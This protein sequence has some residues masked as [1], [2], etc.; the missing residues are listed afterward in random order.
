MALHSTKF[1][2]FSI[3]LYD[4]DGVAEI[5]LNLQED[6][7]VDVNLLLFCYWIAHFKYAPS[8]STW[9]QIFEFSGS[10]KGNIIQ[11]LR[12]TR[13]SLKKLLRNDPKNSDYAE[14]IK[15]LK[16][17]ELSAEKIQQEAIQSLL[18]L[19]ETDTQAF[20]SE[21]AMT[22]LSYYFSNLKIPQTKELKSSLEK[23]ARLVTHS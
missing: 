11:P 4:K 20:S 18:E 17:N 10:W 2:D 3:Q 6:L 12:E 23:I 7:G 13:K 22:N 8:K 21:D 16:S 14:L 9:T 1:W 19:T 15:K 5:C